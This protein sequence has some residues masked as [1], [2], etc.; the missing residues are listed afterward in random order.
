[1]NDVVSATTTKTAPPGPAAHWSTALEALGACADAVAWAR[2]QPSLAAA[3]EACARPDWMLWLL[4]RTL[5]PTL[6]EHQQL[7]R[8][9]CACVRTVLCFSPANE[10]RP[11]RAIEAAEAWAANPSAAARD[12]ASAAAR[13]AAEAAASVSPWD[14]A[15]AAGLAALSAGRSDTVK[16]AVSAVINATASA[17]G[18]VA[19]N[20]ATWAAMR[21]ATRKKYCV[22]VRQH[23]PHP[24]TLKASH[25]SLGGARP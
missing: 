15:Q 25:A 22:T 20:G 11:L 5:A 21:A 10:L 19:T 18:R 8:V 9:A 4:G 1:M 2:T 24:P 12:A 16:A 13:D 14:V 7:V 17:A 3:W 6:A 23:F